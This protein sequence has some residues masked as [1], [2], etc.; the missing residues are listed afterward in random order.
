[1]TILQR[2][3]FVGTDH[4]RARPGSTTRK[5][6][7]ETWLKDQAH[8]YE[9]VTAAAVPNASPISATGHIH[10]GSNGAIIRIPLAHIGT[11]ALLHRRSS[12]PTSGGVDYSGYE[13]FYWFPVFVPEGVTSVMVCMFVRNRETAE[14]LRV[15]T[16]T[17]GLATIEQQDGSQA[18]SSSSNPT[19]FTHWLYPGFDDV[20]VVGWLI[21][22]NEGVVN[23][24]KLEAW[25]G[26][27]NQFGDAVN[28]LGEALPLSRWVGGVTVLPMGRGPVSGA[29]AVSPAI[30]DSTT[31]KVPTAFTSFDSALVT[32]DRS[33]NS[34]VL[35]GAL[36][37]D[38]LL[39]EVLT[40]RPAGN[41]PSATFAGH[42][43]KD[44]AATSLDSSGD[45]IDQPLGSW[46][47]GT[48]RAPASLSGL[49]AE[50]SY[51]DV[52]R[53]EGTFENVWDAPSAPLLYS[54]TAD[55]TYFALFNHRVRIP[56]AVAANLADG[57]GKLKVAA[58]VYNDGNEAFVGA[59]LGDKDE[60]AFD[61][62]QNNS[63]T[64]D[65]RGV[66]TLTG[67]ECT[68]PEE[69]NA[70]KIRLARVT[71]KNHKVGIYGTCLYYER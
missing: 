34:Y 46:A 38:A 37:N 69:V 55:S 35:V 22:V 30:T 71:T 10:D 13:A 25:D 11:R 60:G 58:L 23:L 2:S 63:T 32:N 67:V 66:V 24:V 47:Y 52:P 16:Q 3:T 54:G 39:R 56:A 18:F 20:M 42:N 70:L 12:A 40:G 51:E 8:V 53:G 19:A 50:Y 49:S 61:T 7:V 68:N 26:Y 59:S 29:Q 17:T 15:T 1:M 31:V 45:D 27:W 65:P 41:R 21:A 64:S 5:S 62:E 28:G 48:M 57:T 4:T 6:D 33:I 14:S 43:H 36:K 44:D 9:A